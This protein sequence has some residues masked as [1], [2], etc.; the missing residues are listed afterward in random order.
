MRRPMIAGNWKMYKDVS[1]AIELANGIKRSVF[2]TNNVDIV[3]CPPFTNLSDVGEMLNDGE[4]ALGAQNCHWEEEGAYTGEI[5]AGMLKSIGCK[6]V[7]IGHSERRGLFGETD[8]SVNAKI[9]A[10]IEKGLVPIMCVG[11]TLEQREEGKTLEIVKKQITGGLEGFNEEYLD[12]L[13]VAYEPVWAI[14]TGKT[15]T[16]GQ[17]QEVH[18]AIRKLLGELFSETFSATRRI[19]YGGSVKPDNIEKLMSEKDIDGGLIGGASLKVESFVDLVKKTSRLYGG[20][21][22]D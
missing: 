21:Q 11:E 10:V 5:S 19:L 7:I 18:A 15:A 9:K 22:K 17:A 6:Y 8:K 1:E 20:E 13:V 2:D 12:T 3:I 16:P 4:I 14:G